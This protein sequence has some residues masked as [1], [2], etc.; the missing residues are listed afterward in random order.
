MLSLSV[1]PLGLASP[2]AVRRANVQLV[3]ADFF[4]TAAWKTL[5]IELDT[6]PMFAIV[7]DNGSPLQSEVGG[8]RSMLFFSDVKDASYQLGQV[9]DEY[10]DLN[11]D[12][13]PTGL[14]SAWKAQAAGDAILVPST[15]ELQ[16]AGVE[17]SADQPLVS[18]QG[19][20]AFACMEL[21]SMRADGT[22]CIPLFMSKADAQAA[23]AETS[24]DVRS[25]PET[26]LAPPKPLEISTVSLDVAIEQVVT[27]EDSPDF[28][29]I[30]SSES[31]EAI[32]IAMRAG[33]A[34]V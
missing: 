15:S 31:V 3:A 10:P 26:L 20:P 4:E 9:R 21:E 34:E 14:G 8:R 11:L 23:V 18:S 25:S 17:V 28:R 16:A 32:R 30:A 22:P 6:M 5:E 13:K 2:P 19:L 12:I 33:G 24:P 27:V 29:F 7:D 1:L